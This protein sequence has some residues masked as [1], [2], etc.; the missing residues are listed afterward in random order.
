MQKDVI[1]LD[2]EKKSLNSMLYLKWLLFMHLTLWQSKNSARSMLL[3]E[4][5]FIPL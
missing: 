4:K 5:V 1:V 3:C 2:Q